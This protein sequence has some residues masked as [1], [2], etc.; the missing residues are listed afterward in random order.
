MRRRRERQPAIARIASLSTL[1]VG[2][3]TDVRLPGRAR[4]LR[5]DP[6]GATELVA[7]SQKCTH[8][9]CA[10][11]PEPEKGVLHCPCHE[12]YFDLR[13]AG[14]SPGRRRRPL[15]RDHARGRGDEVYATGVE[16]RTV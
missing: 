10:V 3:A 1:P 5:A 6:H 11:V 7:Y 4:Q 12:G 15:P 8:L 9:S 2:A 14:P 16:E 13:P